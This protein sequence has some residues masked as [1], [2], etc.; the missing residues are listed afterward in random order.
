LRRERRQPGRCQSQPEKIAAARAHG[1][2]AALG[3]GLGFAGGRNA[4]HQISTLA[5]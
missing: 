2:T 5:R 3:A 4:Q 1:D